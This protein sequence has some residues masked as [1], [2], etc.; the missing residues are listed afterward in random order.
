MV[1]YK[2]SSEVS[3][4]NPAD[5]TVAGVSAIDIIDPGASSLALPPPLPAPLFESKRN[6][7]DY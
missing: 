2:L 7:T 3:V 6:H 1:C 4:A 5:D